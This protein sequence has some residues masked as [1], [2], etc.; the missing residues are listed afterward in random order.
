MSYVGIDV[1]KDAC[2]ATVV[3]RTGRVKHRLEF[4]N[5]RE[6]FDQLEGILGP[7]ST[8]VVEAG[9]Y[10]YPLH[11][12]FTTK[13]YAVLV[14]HPRGI[15][16]ITESE[17]KTDRHDSEV[18]AQLARVDYLPRAYIP[19][20]DILRHRELLR[21][22]L[23]MANQ[24]TRVKTRI[25]AFLAKQGEEPPAKLFERDGMTWLKESVKWADSR[26]VVL[27]LM[28]DELEELQAR[29]ER[30]DNVLAG[31]AIDN[32]DVKLLM[33]IPGIDY[34]LALVIVAEIG[35]IDRF[36]TA[37]A[38]RSY[39]GCA[40]RVRESAGKNTGR[41]TTRSRCP[42]LKTAMS[43]AAQTAVRYDNPIK[44]AFDRRMKKTNKP[45]RAHAVARRKMCD[46]VRTLLL[47]GEPC[48]WASSASIERKL[49][50]LEKRNDR[51]RGPPTP[52]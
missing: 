27:A 44:T 23:D 51:G 39:A 22:R 36:P 20:P 19:H 9:T 15:R 14:A 26:D 17:K 52:P 34:Y 40:P 11:D 31:L 38:F 28:V 47:S 4:D 1:G 12:H 7:R 30:I 24:S 32:D 25:R 42:R 2:V 10:V 50:N 21:A 37:E 18:L 35:D 33:T 48:R 5:R 8:L 3:T 45:A 46:L 16:Q 29:R 41:G 6:G 43:L 13:G 49:N